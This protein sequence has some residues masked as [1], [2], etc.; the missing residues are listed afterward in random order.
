[1]LEG[2]SNGASIRPTVVAA[3]AARSQRAARVSVA[4]P[5]STRTRRRNGMPEKRPPPT[6]RPAGGT[7][8]GDRG[9]H[10]AA[11]CGW[12]AFVAVSEKNSCS[13]P[14]ES[15]ARSSVTRTR[16]SSATRATISRVTRPPSTSTVNVWSGSMS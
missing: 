2:E 7:G 8:L 12:A 4:L 6:V 16:F 5:H 1:M 11:S 15:D 14:P 13:S 3:T 9:G 10:A